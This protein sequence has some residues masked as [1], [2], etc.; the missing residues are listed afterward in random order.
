M[1]ASNGQLPADAGAPTCAALKRFGPDKTAN[2]PAPDF[3]RIGHVSNAAWVVYTILLLHVNWET[4][5][6]FPS[7]ATI[8]EISGMHKGTIIR[9]IRELQSAEMVNVSHRKSD[10]GDRDNNL[11]RL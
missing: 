5:E 11:Y 3:S 1:S 9:A 8:S 7:I 2:I 6:C 10:F 4:G